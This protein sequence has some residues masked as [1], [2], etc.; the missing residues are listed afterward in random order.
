MARWIRKVRGY[1][2]KW[3]V[4]VTLGFLERLCLLKKK[5]TEEG[6]GVNCGFS[7]KSIPS[8]G[9]SKQKGPEARE[10][11]ACLRTSKDDSEAGALGAKRES[12]RIWHLKD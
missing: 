3:G 4:G 7:R 6:E 2:F 1:N 12:D 9:T 11:L 5:K 10:C 8:R